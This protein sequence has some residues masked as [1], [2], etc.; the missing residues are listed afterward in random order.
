MNE[1]AYRP[2]GWPAVAARLFTSDVEGLAGFMRDVFGAAGAAA[3]GRPAEMW[4]GGSV[5]LVSDG[6]GVRAHGGGF[7]YV[8]VPDVDAAAARAQRAGARIV[9]PVTDLPYGDRRATILDPFGNHWQIASR[10]P[11]D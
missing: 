7:L 11:G 5:V 9:E 2:E 6:E 10:R 3:P 4:I 8:Y 1:T